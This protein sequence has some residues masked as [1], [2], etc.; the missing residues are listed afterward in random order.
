MRLF[1]AVDPS[2]EVTALIDRA[3]ARLRPGSPSARWVAASSIHVTLA[4]L[5]EI[6]ESVIPAIT[7]ALAEVA[8][9]HAPFSLHFRGGGSFGSPRRPKI[10]WAGVEGQRDGLAALQ[11]D[12]EASLVPLGYTPEARGF[13]PHVTLA[14]ARDQGG[15]P[16]LAAAAAALR[17]ED[18]GQTEIASL[19]LYASALGP[20]G[21]RYT[22]VST[23][24][25]GA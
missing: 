23:A 5:G 21:A 7:A 24:R 18:F 15:D 3:I 13:S 2:P 10:L 17:D 20:G 12:V 9:R 11:R 6:D 14:R 19:I 25:L 1:V 16:T 8:A 4:F 22:P